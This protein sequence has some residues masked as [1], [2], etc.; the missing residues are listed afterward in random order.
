MC[1]YNGVATIT[2]PVRNSGILQGP[3]QESVEDLPRTTR[4][5][6]H[7]RCGQ[8]VQCAS[9]QAGRAMT[10]LPL[11]RVLVGETAGLISM[12][13]C[14][15]AHFAT[16]CFHESHLRIIHPATYSFISSVISGWKDPSED[17]QR[18]VGPT[19][20]VKP[21]VGRT[22]APRISATKGLETGLTRK[23]RQKC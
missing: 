5:G 2:S 6:R 9:W 10:R 18:D 11:R 4:P 19:R 15:S 14:N 16:V 12:Q 1:I 23:K 21:P 13:K 8:C 3:D 7:G 20:L 17:S 22:T